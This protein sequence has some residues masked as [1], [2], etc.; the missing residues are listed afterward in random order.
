L[1]QISG[2][3]FAHNVETTVALSDAPALNGSEERIVYRITFEPFGK[4]DL[5]AAIAGG[6]FPCAAMSAVSDFEHIVDPGQHD[7]RHHDL[8]SA[9]PNRAG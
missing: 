8:A 1:V 5:P 6:Q 3:A 2:Y 7:D 9:L 4:D